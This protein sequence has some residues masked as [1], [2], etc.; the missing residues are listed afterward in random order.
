MEASGYDV[1]IGYIL[2]FLIPLAVALVAT[3]YAG[4]LATRMGIIAH[5]T[6][7]RYHSSPIPYLGGVAVGVAFLAIAV[8]AAGASA[9]LFTVVL[10]GLA[11]CV[12]GFLDDRRT[13][14]P[15]VKIAVEVSAALALWF[16]GIRAELFHIYAVD[17]LVTIFWVVMITNAL[18]LLDNM[19]G[20]AAGVAAISSL[21]FFVIAA[22]QGDFVVA[23]LCLALAGANLGFLRHNYPRATIFLGDAGALLIGFLLAAL[24]LETQLSGHSGLLWAAIPILALAVP[25]VD[26]TF[27]VISR[28]RGRRPFYVGGTDHTSHHLVR[29]GLSSRVAALLTYAMQ[30][31]ASL[32]ALWVVISASLMPL[33]ITPV[34]LACVA[35][36]LWSWLIVPARARSLTVTIVEPDAIDL[37]MIDLTKSSGTT[38]NPAVQ[39]VLYDGKRGA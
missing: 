37:D 2:S 33:F 31:T 5:P 19:D 8:F 22:T 7:D 34:A 30:A 36:G 23:S 39:P 20:L 1:P 11:V 9:E 25:I 24:G 17:L 35:L 18:N 3:P 21:T 29:L 32:M 26:M 6:T 28:I 38:I 10:A 14:R 13:V 16:V 15:L 4:K 12:V 27:V